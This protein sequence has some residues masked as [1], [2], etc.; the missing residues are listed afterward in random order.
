MADTVFLRVEIAFEEDGRG[1][2]RL[3][4]VS[5]AAPAAASL[6]FPSSFGSKS[7]SSVWTLPCEESEVDVLRGD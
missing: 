5:F 1:A 2:G 4:R 7:C 6:G 3:C